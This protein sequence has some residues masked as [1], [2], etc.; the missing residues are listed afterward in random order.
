MRSMKYPVQCALLIAPYMT[1]QHGFKTMGSCIATAFEIL[2]AGL[3]R[4]NGLLQSFL[5]S[6]LAAKSA[7]RIGYILL[8]R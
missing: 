7:A 5:S 1:G 6:F 4:N 8:N 2:D 3:R